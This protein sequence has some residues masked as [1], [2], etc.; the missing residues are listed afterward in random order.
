[1]FSHGLSLCH[2]THRLTVTLFSHELI[3]LLTESPAD[4]AGVLP[5]DIILRIDGQVVSML[6]ADNIAKIIRYTNS[7]PL[8]LHMF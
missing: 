6:A 3:H 4:D 2:H 1:M 7:P 8:L 5:N